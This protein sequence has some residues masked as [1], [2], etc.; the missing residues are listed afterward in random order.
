MDFIEWFRCQKPEEL[1]LLSTTLSIA[2]SKGL[3]VNELNAIGNFLEAIAENVF[4]I[5]SQRL[6]NEEVGCCSTN[7]Q[8]TKEMARKIEAEFT[9]DSLSKNEKNIN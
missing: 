7:D 3:T 5:T 8:D 9:K 4:L 6:L 1:V 2:I